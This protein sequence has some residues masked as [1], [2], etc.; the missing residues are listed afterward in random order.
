MSESARAR[1]SLRRVVAS[2]PAPAPVIGVSLATSGK[3]RRPEL[4]A[5][6]ARMLAKYRRPVSG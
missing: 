6:V 1:R 3:D 4:V 2:V 5:W